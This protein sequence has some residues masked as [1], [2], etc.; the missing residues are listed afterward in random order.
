LLG[1]PILQWI[2]NDP[3]PYGIG[4]AEERPVTVHRS[5]HFKSRHIDLSCSGA[6]VVGVDGRAD[7][8]LAF[9]AVRVFLERVAAGGMPIR[10]TDEDAPIV[11]ASAVNSAAWHW[12]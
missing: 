11:G 2:A 4:T 3:A 6:P 12:P 1:E 8:A 5:Q 10:L 9:P 7:E